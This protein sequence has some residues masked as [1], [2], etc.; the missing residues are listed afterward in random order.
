MA[1]TSLLPSFILTFYKPIEIL[2]KPQ[3][4]SR[5]PLMKILSLGL[6]LREGE[7]AYW[8]LIKTWVLFLYKEPRRKIIV[9]YLQRRN[10]V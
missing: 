4:D 2:C 8:A 10:K 7:F 9:R 6:L 5:D 3:G 1:T